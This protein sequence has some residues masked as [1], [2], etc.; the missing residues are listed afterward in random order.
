MK[1]NIQQITKTIEAAHPVKMVS[2]KAAPV[3]KTIK[4]GRKKI[5]KKF[6]RWMMS[7]TDR[8]LGVELTGRRATVTQLQFTVFAEGEPLRTGMDTVVTAVKSVYPEWDGESWLRETAVTTKSVPPGGV[9]QPVRNDK[10]ELIK[11]DIEKGI[12]VL[13]IKVI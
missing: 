5:K 8:M 10:V 4:H 13:F 7:S 3:Q 9:V 2:A 11:L 1:T 6:H 12:P